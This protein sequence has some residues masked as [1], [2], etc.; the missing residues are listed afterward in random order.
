MVPCTWGLG[1]ITLD[2]SLSCESDSGVI[3][4]ADVAKSTTRKI[5]S[6]RESLF[7]AIPTSFE[8][9]RFSAARTNGFNRFYCVVDSM[10]FIIPAPMISD[11][12]NNSHRA[13][14][15]PARP[16]I[17]HSSPSIQSKPDYR[18]AE[19]F[20]SM[21]GGMEYTE[22]WD[23]AWWLQLPWLLFSLSPTTQ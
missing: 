14:D 1:K 16:L 8:K 17:W 7:S 4:I 3:V 11:N 18:P 5:R 23:H 13:E 15:V 6:E 2:P 19:G 12:A 20:S 9:P 21:A 22:V 10:Y